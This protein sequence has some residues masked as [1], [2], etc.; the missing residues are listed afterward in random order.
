MFAEKHTRRNLQDV[1]SLVNDDPRFDAKTVSQF[2][3][4]IARLDKVGNDIDTLL[5]DA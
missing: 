2:L 3:T 1:F 4:F 5:L